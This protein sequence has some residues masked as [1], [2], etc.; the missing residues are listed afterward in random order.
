[1]QDFIF[2]L[3]ILSR[4][5]LGWFNLCFRKMLRKRSRSQ[6]KDQHMGHPV[7]DVSDSQ[8]HPDV[9][10]Q[11]HKPNSFF[12]LP[13]VFVGLSPKASELESINSP[14]SPLDFR[15]FSSL[16]NPFR[17]P[18]SSQENHHKS[19][20][21]S[22]VGL[23]IIDSLDD[24]TTSGKVLRSSDSK[25]ILF[26]AQ[27]GIKIPN[28]RSRFES[29]EAPNSLPNN[30]A[31]FP[32]KHIVK[33]SKLRNGSSSVHFE[34]GEA[35]LVDES[36]GKFRSCSLD[37][38]NVGS[39]LGNLRTKLSRE[40]FCLDDGKSSVSVPHSFI[41]GNQ[42]LNSSS[43]TELTCIGVPIG[44]QN[45]FIGP[46]SASEIELS[47]DYTCVR[48]HGPNAKTTHIY[49]DCILGCHDNELVEKSKNGNKDIALSAPD[50]GPAI[51]ITYPSNNFSSFCFS[52]K[53]T[54][55]GE[56]IYMY[57]GDTFCSWSCRSEEISFQEKLEQENSSSNSEELSGTSMFIA[58]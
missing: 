6:Q 14:T 8:Y 16:G 27:M 33:P 29:F 2:M 10:A 31:I 51:S 20:G 38:G 22:K 7:S 17:S 28:V 41:A 58:T 54:L 15:V 37:N 9:S 50:A 19:W 23:S 5:V 13:G 53:K 36:F 52:C 3:C 30:Y 34:I 32:S 44:S 24:E 57:R 46:L 42:N 40:I 49:S 11:K 4:C 48:T 12:S 35:S 21:C 39:Q 1:M 45:S 18:K 55:E 25:N 26:G 47:E 56:D 43:S